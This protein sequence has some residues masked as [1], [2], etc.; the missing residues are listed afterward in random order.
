MLSKGS[1]RTE[2][3]KV[4]IHSFTLEISLD[5]AIALFSR[6]HPSRFPPIKTGRIYPHFKRNFFN[7]FPSNSLQIPEQVMHRGNLG[8]TDQLLRQ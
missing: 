2:F 5:L 1:N 8:Q 6:C 7:I 3:I 4:D